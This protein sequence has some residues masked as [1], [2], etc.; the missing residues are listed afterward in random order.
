MSAQLSAVSL[1]QLPEKLSLKQGQQFFRE[2]E[3]SMN[4]VRPA[5]VLD[6]S[7][8]QQMDRST[9][10][11]LLCCLEEALKRNGDVRLCG[12]QPEALHPLQIA[13][14]DRLFKIFDTT[15]QAV[16]SFQRRVVITS[17]TGERQRQTAASLAA[18]N[19]A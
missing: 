8:V 10:H 18:E 6:C 19:A 12:L 4:V 13:G 1:K 7:R 5:I 15:E 2:L 14:V 16:D 11:L 17:P 9:V 3:N